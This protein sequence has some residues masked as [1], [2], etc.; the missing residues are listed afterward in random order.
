MCQGMDQRLAKV[1]YCDAF[2]TAK[3]LDKEQVT[4]HLTKLEREKAQKML[5][6]TLAQQE[7][8]LWK[9]FGLEEK[10]QWDTLYKM[11]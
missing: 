6:Y 10:W 8:S 3:V 11:R 5:S 4:G 7:Q 2:K 1:L 9:S